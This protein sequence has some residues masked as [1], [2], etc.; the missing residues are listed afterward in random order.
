MG[1]NGLTFSTTLGGIDGT[2]GTYDASNSTFFWSASARST[3]GYAY[4]PGL[5][6]QNVNRANGQTVR[7]VRDNISTLR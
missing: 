5:G 4:A 3:Y 2:D 1:N 6:M 7:C